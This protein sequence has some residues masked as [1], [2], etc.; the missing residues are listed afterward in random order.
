LR[1]VGQ[2][3][4]I[5]TREHHPPAFDKQLA[6]NAESESFGRRGNE[7]A[8]TGKIEVQNVALD[9]ILMTMPATLSGGTV[10]APCTPSP[11]QPL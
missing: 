2:T 3:G 9:V 8:A 10:T 1:G 6:R 5:G 4:G 7:K 11:F